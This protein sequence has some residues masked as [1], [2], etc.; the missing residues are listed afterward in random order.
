ME[1]TVRSRDPGARFIAVVTGIGLLSLAGV[2]LAE[3]AKPKLSVE[4]FRQQLR[5]IVIAE[6]ELIVGTPLSLT[7]LREGFDTRKR[8]A[9]EGFLLPEGAAAFEGRRLN[10]SVRAGEPLRPVDFAP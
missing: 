6:R 4:A 5:P 7:M 10:R 1:D 3:A 9:D 8:A 2:A